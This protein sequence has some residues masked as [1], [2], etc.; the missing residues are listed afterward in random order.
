MFESGGW[1]S[2]SIRS[3]FNTQ[4]LWVS[5]AANNPI[6][7]PER[8]GRRTAYIYS[9]LEDQQKSGYQFRVI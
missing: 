1:Y 5:R 3:N 7:K 6:E 2:D 4:Y 8:S 9:R